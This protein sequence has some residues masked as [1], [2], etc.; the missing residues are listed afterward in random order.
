[1]S[2]Y[3]SYLKAE[4]SRGM[5]EDYSEENRPH[6]AEAERLGL[7]PEHTYV[8]NRPE[9]GRYFV[10]HPSTYEFG[11]IL[12]RDQDSEEVFELS[13]DELLSDILD[14]DVYVEG[15]GHNYNIN[16]VVEGL[17]RLETYLSGR[18]EHF[19]AESARQNR[20]R[21]QDLIGVF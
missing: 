21:L 12:F 13:K 6:F 4:E 11:N 17:K 10:E 18:G 2:D 9:A 15:I 8:L 16:A 20:E 7:R 3:H 14:G 1:M 19:G 5:A